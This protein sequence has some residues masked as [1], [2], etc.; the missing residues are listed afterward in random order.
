MGRCSQA[1]VSLPETKSGHIGGAI[2][3]GLARP[4]CGH[5]FLWN[6]LPAHPCS[7]ISAF[8]LDCSSSRTIEELREDGVRQIQQHGRPALCRDLIDA[9]PRGTMDEVRSYVRLDLPLRSRFQTIHQ[10]CVDSSPQWRI[11]L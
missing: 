4:E 3:P 10:C 9:V 7:A 2:R 8:E 11:L 1:Q 6:G 5:R